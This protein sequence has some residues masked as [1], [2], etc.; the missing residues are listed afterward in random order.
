MDDAAARQRLEALLADLDASS[1]TLA[2]E[3]G[4]TGELSRIDQHSA[5]AASELTEMERDDALREVVD[6]QREQVL[7]ALSRLDGGTYGRCVD[8]GTALPDE[9][10]DARPEAARCVSCQ[11]DL[12][13]AR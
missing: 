4:P 12:E 9:R 2:S 8:C 6:N 13:M 5:E 1:R 10:L 7:E 11:H 3:A